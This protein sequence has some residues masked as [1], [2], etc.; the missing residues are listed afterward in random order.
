M[1][2][3]CCL[4]GVGRGEARERQGV[5]RR[6]SEGRGARE[7]HRKVAQS[8]DCTCSDHLQQSV[9]VGGALAG[10]SGLCSNHSTQAVKP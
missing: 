9:C 7:G 10:R 2:E 5:M 1:W 3:D 8:I 4:F 6:R